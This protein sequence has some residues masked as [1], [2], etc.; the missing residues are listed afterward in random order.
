MTAAGTI[1]ADKGP[2]HVAVILCFVIALVVSLCVTPFSM[3]LAHKVGLIDTPQDERRMHKQP[4]PCFGGLAIFAGFMLAVLIFENTPLRNIF[5]TYDLPAS[6]PKLHAAMIGGALMFIVGVVDDRFDLRASIKLVGQIACACAAYFL[7]VH[8]PDF[9]LF[10]W[11]FGANSVLGFLITIIWIVAIT[12]MINLVDGL[13]G[14]AGG[15][16]GIAALAIAYSAYIVGLYTVAF[17]MTVLAGA[18]FGFLPFNFYPAK[19]FM[20]DSGA[21]FLGFMLATLSIIGPA[22]GTAFM[23]LIGPVVVLGVPLFDTAFAMIRRILRGQSIFMP[24]KGHLHHQLTRI[25]IGQR[26]SVLMIYGVCGIMGIASIVLSRGFV[27]EAIGLIAIA[28]L[29]IF[30]LIWGWNRNRE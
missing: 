14:L 13:D 23:A 25:G 26:R 10:G 6:I 20:G 29:F 15:I 18:A 12:N 8:I 7:G 22:K 5:S 4:V 2:L 11:H 19:S 9:N 27:L 17:S 1:I 30:V 21:M 28:V 24:D 16:A 3:W